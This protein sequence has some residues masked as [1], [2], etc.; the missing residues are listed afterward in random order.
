MLTENV[1]RNY[2]YFNNYCSEII[3]IQQTA[4]EF[5]STARYYYYYYYNGLAMAAIVCGLWKTRAFEK[6]DE[7]V[8][9]KPW[10]RR[11]ILAK[12]PD[13]I[14]PNSVDCYRVSKHARILF[15]IHHRG[16]VV[17][18][19]CPKLI[20]RDLQICTCMS[21]RGP[22]VNIYLHIK[23]CVII[24][25]TEFYPFLRQKCDG[26]IHCANRIVKLPSNNITLI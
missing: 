3:I 12:R 14:W 22:A 13:R 26:D 9:D 21:L 8:A 11:G 5:S 20:F 24:V 23:S 2:Y 1:Y 19:V 7:K 10:R 16:V 6:R 17:V 15:I 18:E 25:Y 4:G